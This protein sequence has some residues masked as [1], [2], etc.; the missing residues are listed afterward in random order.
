[1]PFEIDG[2]KTRHCLELALDSSHQT[3]EL[4]LAS[5]ARG[6]VGPR[7][8]SSSSRAASGPAPTAARLPPDRAPHE[9]LSDREYQVLRMI[10]T[11]RTVSEISAELGLSVKT[12]STY[13]SR[14]LEKMKLRTSAELMHYAITNRLVP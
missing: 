5:S 1:V 4:R 10:A 8:S 14:I 3:C 2:Q 13:R 12:I 6:A 9:T 7:L 11:G